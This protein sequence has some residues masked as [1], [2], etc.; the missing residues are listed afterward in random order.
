MKKV[1][2]ISYNFAP[3]QTVGAIRP[4]KVAKYLCEM[5]YTVDVVSVKP[6]GK[7]DHTMDESVEKINK[8]YYIDFQI[9]PQK[10]VNITDKSTAVVKKPKTQEVIAE[11]NVTLKAKVK[12]ILFEEKKSLRSGKFVSE[13]K[14][15]IEANREA[16]SEYDVCFSTF[17]PY[18]SH[19]CALE[20]KKQ[21]PNIRWI[22]DFRDPMVVYSTNPLMKPKVAALQE[23][24]CANADALVAVSKGYYERIF[25]N[26]YDDKSYVIYNGYDRDD[27][28]PDE[29]KPDTDKYTFACV[30]SLYSG[31]R[32]ASALFEALCELIAEGK[33]DKSDLSLKYAG[34]QAGI[35]ATQA[36]PFGLQDIIDD[37]G[38]L[39]R[40]KCLSLQGSARH[41]LLVTWNGEGEG[42]MIP[43]KFYEYLLMNRPTIC[44][45]SGNKSGHELR[46][47]IDD[48]KFGFTYE[49][50]NKK[51]DFELLK[52]YLYKDYLLFKDGKNSDYAPV[53]EELEKYD[54]RNLTKQIEALF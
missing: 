45:V 14:K 36:K 34:N 51:N 46:S 35:L 11:A 53:T 40:D 18:V 22:A 5:G 54:F 30:G 20:M 28:N 31:R 12:E 50:A 23:K 19:M 38:T 41:N 10:T 33:M 39:P 1:L 27:Y 49:E 44:I 21:F 8:F 43:L 6:F 13:F 29:I 16:F 48:G 3:R 7:I 52:D 25:G 42:G 15:I 24:V 4:T 37:Y 26:R 2:I 17:G 9:L 32:D 47:M